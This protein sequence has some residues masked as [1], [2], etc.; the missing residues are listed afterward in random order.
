MVRLAEDAQAWL[1][2]LGVEWQ[3]LPTPEAAEAFNKLPGP[4]ALLLHVTC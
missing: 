4:K 1:A 2:E 3:L